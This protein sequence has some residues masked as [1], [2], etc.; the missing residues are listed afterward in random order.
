M[1]DFFTNPTDIDVID[2]DEQTIYSN[3]LILSATPEMAATQAVTRFETGTAKTFQF[4]KYESLAAA[5]ALSDGVD[6]DSTLLSDSVVTLTPV[7]EGNVVSVTKHAAYESNLRARSA[8]SIL[9]GRNMGE[10]LEARAITALEGSGSTAV[11]PN[12]VTAVGSLT[13]ND[14][15]DALM[16]G[17]LF[18]KLKRSN[19][20]GIFGN[21][22]MAISHDDPLHDLREDTG[23]GGWIDVSEYADPNSV[24]NN[25]VGMY[26]GIRWVVSG[27]AS[28]TT[29]GGSSTVDSYEVHV[30]GSDALGFAASELPHLVFTPANDKLQRMPHIGWYGVL[31]FDSINTSNQVDGQ[32]ATSVGA[33]T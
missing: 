5:S 30:V 26:K 31:I 20:P 25:E 22:Y 7:E 29:D 33:N 18:N 32:V 6:P 17:R 11:Y 10:T 4:A 23:K 14:T 27:K 13:A 2:A 12:G 24:L 19:I 15:L 3:N 28:V 9:I 16:A 8:A 21:K 1:A